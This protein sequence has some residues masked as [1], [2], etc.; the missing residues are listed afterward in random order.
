MVR[1]GFECGMPCIPDQKVHQQVK[2]RHELTEGESN[3][4]RRRGIETC[5]SKRKQ[6]TVWDTYTTKDTM[7][8]EGLKREGGQQSKWVVRPG[9]DQE[10]KGLLL[11]VQEKKIFLLRDREKGVLKRRKQRQKR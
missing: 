9:M 8:E 7:R 3:P 11:L 1:S 2:C 4:P 6:G 10:G 5:L